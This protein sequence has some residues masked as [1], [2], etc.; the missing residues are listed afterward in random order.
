MRVTL[1]IQDGK[2]LAF[3]NFIQSLDF[4]T[5]NSDESKSENEFVLS[6]EQL[7]ILE[8]RRNDRMQG[9]SQTYSWDEVMSSLNK[10]T[11]K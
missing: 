5:I 2:A 10:R 3:L 1:D 11:Q 4:V 7:S 6:E 8:E 9:K